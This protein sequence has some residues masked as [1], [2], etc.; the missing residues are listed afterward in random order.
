L[1]GNIPSDFEDI[2]NGLIFIIN[3]KY[4]CN[5]RNLKK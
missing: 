5:S 4:Y 3:P 1:N 2:Y